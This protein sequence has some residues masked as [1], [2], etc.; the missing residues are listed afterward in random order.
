MH[1]FSIAATTIVSATIAARGSPLPPSTLHQRAA[2]KLHILTTGAE[3][4]DAAAVKNIKDGVADAKK[5]AA[6]AIKK[7]K[8]K[9]MQSSNGFFQLF[10]SHP[11]ANEAYANT[12]NNQKLPTPAGGEAPEPVNLIRFTPRGLQNT[13]SSEESITRIKA[14]NDIGSS[15]FPLDGEFPLPFLAFT[16]IHE[17]QHSIP[18]VDGVG[19]QLKDQVDFEGERAYGLQQVQNMDPA[20][21]P[22]NPQ[23]FAWFALLSV[24]KPDLFTAACKIDGS[25]IGA[26]TTRS[27]DIFRSLVARVTKS[28]PKAKVAVKAP[29]KKVPA[30][31]LPK[32]AAS[33]KVPTKATAKSPSVKAPVRPATKPATKA[34]TKPAAAKKVSAK[35]AAKVPAPKKVPTK[36]T[37]K[38]P[39][40][41][42]KPAAK[43]PI[44]PPTSKKVPTK[45]TAK[46]PA[47][48]KPP[49]K[50][51][52]LPVKKPVASKAASAVPAK[53]SAS[54]KAKAAIPSSCPVR[55]K[56]PGTDVKFL[57]F[58][59]DFL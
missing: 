12:K 7:L 33:K 57:D 56:I 53:P 16:I 29:A 18:L 20:K 54:S 59:G 51:P 25:K 37:T 36:P 15:A 58:E 34:S 44:K 49:V 50:K 43:A 27:L 4:C 55:A 17:A 46:S 5:L 30:K 26:K 6:Q 41:A 23:N 8:V 45:A 39:V 52:T 22:Q 1:F 42:K 28:K 21:K 11:K 10:A 2:T 38:V 32:P 35:P 9:D 31:A 48:V 47:G 40:A 14:S 24:A 19:N 3:A 13:E